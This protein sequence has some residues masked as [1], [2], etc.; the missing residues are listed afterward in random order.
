[1]CH[2]FII[3]PSTKLNLGTFYILIPETTVALSVGEQESTE[4]DTD[5]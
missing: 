5:F 4:C 1:M 3:Y 2:I